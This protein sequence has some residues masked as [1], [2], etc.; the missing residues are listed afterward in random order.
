ML[1][2]LLATGPPL[3]FTPWSVEPAALESVLGW[4]AAG[5][6]S[7]LECG[8]GLTTLLI[9]RLL[10]E[11][12]SGRVIALEHLPG[13][14]EK[15]R[16]AIDAEG[17]GEQATVTD[18]PLG[19]HPLAEPGCAWYA[20]AAVEQLP[21]ELDLL[22]VDGPPAGEAGLE[23]SRYPALPALASH[24][25][26]GA[27]VVLDDADRPGEAWVLDRWE[28][29]RAISFDRRPG[30]RIAVGCMFPPREDRVTF[31]TERDR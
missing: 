11:R 18:A 5:R 31:D 7:V 29:E 8:S 28:H 2:R 4:V 14:A 22:F 6:E 20:Q 24:L 12:G 21:R 27:L 13:V 26:P 30:E 16:A 17:L 25:A 3:E 23:R 10:R 15:V 19:P 9:A 1:D